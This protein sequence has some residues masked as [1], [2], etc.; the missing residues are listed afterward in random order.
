MP[1]PAPYTIAGFLQHAGVNKL[2]ILVLERK[3]QNRF[4][5]KESFRKKLMPG[6]SNNSSAAA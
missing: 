2:F 4:T 5:Q 3:S 6:R 1:G